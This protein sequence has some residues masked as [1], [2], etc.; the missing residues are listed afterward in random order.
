M[1][2][3]KPHNF[4]KKRSQVKYHRSNLSS[5]QQYLL[6]DI[7]SSFNYGYLK[8][9]NLSEEEKTHPERKYSVTFLSKVRTK[10][11]QTCYGA[12]NYLYLQFQNNNKAARKSGQNFLVIKSAK[13]LRKK[14]LNLYFYCCSDFR[15]ESN[16]IFV[17]GVIF[18]SEKFR[19][20]N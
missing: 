7:K 15:N 17:L 11:S 18:Y 2:V 5:G 10:R 16:G 9:R 8:S 20:F 1:A 4:S 6:N 14:T 13:K 3:S 19:L 12:L